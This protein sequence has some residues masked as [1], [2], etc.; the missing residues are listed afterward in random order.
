MRLFRRERDKPPNNESLTAALKAGQRDPRGDRTPL[1]QAMLESR[2]IVALKEPPAPAELGQP[3]ALKFA[4]FEGQGARAIAGFTDPETFE[5]Q[6]KAEP[7]PHATLSMQQLCR[8]AREGGITIV[9]NPAGPIGYHLTVHE[10][11][12]L[13]EGRLPNAAEYQSVQPGT[14]V[15]IGMPAQRPPEE[16]L[17]AMREAAARSGAKEVFWF[18]ITIGATPAH[19]GLAVSPPQKEISDRLGQAIQ[20]LWAAFSPD[21]AVFDIVGLA[22]DEI[23][24]SIRAAGERLYP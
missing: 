23:A 8:S 3:V 19:L 22:D 11:E 18:W 2:L 20:P 21:N 6:F 14:R 15:L 13:S 24:R 10:I 9:I 7:V 12:A 4:L 1:Y 17:S 5:R 16:T